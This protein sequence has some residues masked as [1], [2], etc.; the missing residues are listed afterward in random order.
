MNEQN[1]ISVI[2]DDTLFDYIKHLRDIL[3]SHINK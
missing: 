3:L 1:N 2:L